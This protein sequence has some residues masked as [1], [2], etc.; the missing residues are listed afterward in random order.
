MRG[1]KK[2]RTQKEEEPCTCN[3]FPYKRGTNLKPPLLTMG[4]RTR[5]FLAQTWQEPAGWDLP[6]SL[7]GVGRRRVQDRLVPFHLHHALGVQFQ[8]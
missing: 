2:R 1:D 5:V 7:L 3:R 4:T 6:F 8:L